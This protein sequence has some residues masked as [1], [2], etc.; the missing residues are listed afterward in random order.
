MTAALDTQRQSMSES[1]QA[2]IDVKQEEM[3]VAIQNKKEEV[4]EALEYHQEKMRG[5]IEQ[6]KEKMEAEKANA[7]D[8][9]LASHRTSEATLDLFQAWNLML[10]D[11]E[12]NG[13]SD[14][15]QDFA[16]KVLQQCAVVG[17]N[18]IDL[19]WMRA[20]GTQHA[21]ARYRTIKIGR[22]LKPG[23][24]ARSHRRWLQNQARDF[25]DDL[26]RLTM[27]HVGT[28]LRFIAESTG[29]LVV[30]H[31][32]LQL[33]IAQCVA[34]RD[35]VGTGTNGLYRLKQA[36]EI[37]LPILKGLIIPPSIRKSISIMERQGFVPSRVIEVNY[38]ITHKGNRR[39]MCTYYYCEHPAQLL[40]NMFRRMFLD[41][42]Y[43][44]SSSFSSQINKLAISIGFD[45]SDKDFVG[46]WRP[47]NRRNGNSGL[48]VQAFA[49]LEGPVAE[50]Y[51]NEIITIGNPAYPT[52]E[53]VQHLVDDF[54]FAM[55]FMAKKG[56]NQIC[57][58][59]LFLPIPTP[60]QL[61]PR[62][63]A[64]TY[65]PSPV[66]ANLVA[67]DGMNEAD[68]DEENEHYI[69]GNNGHAP[70]IVLPLDQ[71]DISVRLIHDGDNA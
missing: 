45:K 5:Q 36:L 49:C 12:D 67:F 40:A 59:S 15:L 61:T 23:G 68:D 70:E 28:I 44:E 33:T 35:H 69:S 51:E 4:E 34:L 11:L 2:A 47:C 58:C 26:G 22:S 60:E 37:F 52:G 38:T 1:M 56:R 24:T 62:Q 30:S 6:Q 16:H 64:V 20:D 65:L 13:P 7:V 8:D 53:T 17:T 41:G 43:E 21:V 27:D 14:I 55:V 71:S 46:T 10:N 54:M 18:E 3:E 9:A 63:T 57:S 66:S 29:Y 50:C 25:V 42:E 32:D 31:D 39:G 48:Y 19:K